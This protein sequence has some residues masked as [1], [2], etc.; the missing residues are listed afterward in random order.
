MNHFREALLKIDS[1][2]MFL[3]AQHFGDDQLN[4]I[5]KSGEINYSRGFDVFYTS[6][7]RHPTAIC[8]RENNTAYLKDDVAVHVVR[9]YF[10]IHHLYS[11]DAPSTTLVVTL[12]NPRDW[13]RRLLC[14]TP[15]CIMMSQGMNS[16]F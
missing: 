6:Y 7:F 1:C 4:E 16:W 14:A 9:A 3:N 2:R 13:P 5:D 10:E 8:A 11:G 12:G 15:A